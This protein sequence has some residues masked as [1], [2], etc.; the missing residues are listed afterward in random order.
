[1]KETDAKM[2]F[3]VH[4]YYGARLEAFQAGLGVVIRALGHSRKVRVYIID[5]SFPWFNEL[6]QRSELPFQIFTREE[7][8]NQFDEIK[9]EMITLD[10]EIC[11]LVN[12]D[13]LLDSWLRIEDFVSLIKEVN[14][15][16]EVII[17]CE[18]KYDLLE[19]LGDYVSSFELKEM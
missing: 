10:N 11:L 17:T 12:F 8:K 15:K 4:F 1:L 3:L 5:D 9:K 18:N 14:K 19:D 2:T 13:L 7:T 6:K 16:N